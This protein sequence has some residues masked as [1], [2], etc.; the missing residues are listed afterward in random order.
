[1]RAAARASACSK[2]ALRKHVGAV[3]LPMLAHGAASRSSIG[4]FA[5]VPLVGVGSAAFCSSAASTPSPVA[6]GDRVSL[7]MSGKLASGEAFGETAGGEPLSFIVGSGD[8]IPGIEEG[9]V[10][11]FK[12]DS[13][14]LEIA[15]EKAFGTQKQIHSVPRKQ[16][17]L[18]KED[19]EGLAVGQYL[20]LQNGQ[21]ARIV[22]LTEESVDID[23]SHPFTGETLYVDITIVDAVARSELSVQEQLVLPE[24]ITPGDN[25]TFPQR[26]DTLVMHYVGKLASDGTVFDSSRDRGQPFQFT[27][28]VGQV[29][30]GWDEGVLRMSKGQ[31][32][33]LN[34][35]SVKGYGSAGAGGVIPPNADLI[36]EVELLDIL[37]R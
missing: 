17:N 3:Q 20:Q 25:A 9:V 37:R 5:G 27:I 12:G 11:L 13:K 30:K 23:L 1:M 18:P 28:G 32:A 10:G 21:Q 8:V 6:V 7:H 31:K 22:K 33:V 26:G 35:P 24:E 34:I 15:P 4:A 19:D 14:S 16:I 2:S 36:F 29:I